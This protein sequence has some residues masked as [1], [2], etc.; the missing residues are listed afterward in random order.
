MNDFYTKLE[1]T[2]SKVAVLARIAVI[3]CRVDEPEGHLVYEDLLNLKAAIDGA[4]LSYREEVPAADRDA[5]RRMVDHDLGITDN[6]CTCAE[7]S[8]YGDTHDTAC[9]LAGR[10]R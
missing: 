9:P 3:A 6:D 7:R 2:L 5:I 4:I 10:R 8:W 1:G